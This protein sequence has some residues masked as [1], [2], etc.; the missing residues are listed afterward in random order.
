M[1]R[2]LYRWGNTLRWGVFLSPWPRCYLR[3]RRVSIPLL[4]VGCVI[5]CCRHWTLLVHIYRGIASAKLSR[6][7]RPNVV[8]APDCAVVNGVH[9][10]IDLSFF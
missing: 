1:S 2:L 8:A 7:H 9:C 5:G 3:R 10:G 4:E 6:Q